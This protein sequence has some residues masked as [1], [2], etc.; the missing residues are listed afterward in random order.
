MSKIIS[1]ASDFGLSDGSVG[2][3]KGVI[4]RIDP[5]IKINDISHG[6]P[7][8]NIKQGSLLLM[9]A[10]QYIP[11]G[12]LLGVVDPGV[13]TDR[14][15]IA[16]ETEWGIMIGPDN[17]LLNLACAT[18]GGAQRGFLLDNQ[19]WIIPS[20]GNT[21]HA[22]D[23]FAPFA[24]GYASGQLKIEEFG[25][26]LDLQNLNQYLIPLTDVSKDEIKGEILWIDHYG[27]C[28]TNVSPEELNGLKKSTGDVV[29]IRI[30]NNEIKTT[31]VETYQGKHLGDVGLVTDSWG[32]VSLFATN[33]NA[34]KILNIEDGA[35]ISFLV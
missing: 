16:L 13:G 29:N 23:V 20:E 32:M 19:N 28:Q 8:Q 2:I 31:W 3:V 30:G 11:Q 9:R 15:P 25:P 18:V 34:S 35:K 7:A 22:R 21:F 27:N 14:K 17:G 10:I 4:N 24:A 6:I 5:D 26:E 12:V 1:F 33:K